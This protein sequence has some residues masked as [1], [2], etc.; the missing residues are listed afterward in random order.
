MRFKSS[1]RNRNKS[2]SGS[3]HG[4]Y[5]VYSS[6]RVDVDSSYDRLRE[7]S[8]RLR[9]LRNDYFSRA[10]QAYSRGQRSLAHILSQKG[11]MMNT[12]IKHSEMQ[13]S[14]KILDM[15]NSEYWNHVPSCYRTLNVHGLHV[16]EAIE[17]VERFLYYNRDQ[18]GRLRIITGWGKNSYPNEVRLL[19][20]LKTYLEENGKLFVEFR[21]GVIEVIS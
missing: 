15:V 4:D 5:E 18:K 11:R 12:A 14:A 7:N 21:P 13:S 9:R 6:A 19:P 20:E 10:S 3:F 1:K 8:Q 16:K 17:A 2:F